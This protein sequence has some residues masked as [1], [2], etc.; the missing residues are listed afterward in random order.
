MFDPFHTK[1][2]S[3]RTFATVQIGAWSSFA[4][5]EITEAQ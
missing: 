2:E 4:R 3:L 1:R 5:F